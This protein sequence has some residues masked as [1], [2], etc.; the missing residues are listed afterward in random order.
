M[1][2]GVGVA[3]GDYPTYQESINIPSLGKSQREI[4]RTQSTMQRTMNQHAAGSSTAPRS[5]VAGR[6][7]MFVMH[8]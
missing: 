2:Q 1:A 7:Y 3:M 4:D 8:A 6:I 5:N